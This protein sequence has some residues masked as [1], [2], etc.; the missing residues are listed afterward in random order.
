MYEY[1]NEQFNRQK[2][3]IKKILK[4][5]LA[6][7]YYSKIYQKNNINLDLINTYNDFRSIP[8]LTKSE[9]N[10]NKFDMITNESKKIHKDT[11]LAFGDDFEKK[12]IYLEKN[13]FY[14]KITSGSTGIPVEIFKSKFDLQREY[15]GLNYFRKKINKTFPKGKYIWIW[16]ANKYIRKYFYDNPEMRV[17][18]DG[19]YGYKYMLDEYSIQSFKIL[20]DFIISEKI[21]WITAPP[22][23]LYYYAKYLVESNTCV[24]FKYIECHSEK[25]YDFQLN[26]IQTV[27]GT[28]PISV[29]SSNEIQ[30]MGISCTCNSMHIIPQN[31]FIE[32]LPNPNGSK[33]VVATSLSCMNLPIIRY[34]LCDIGDF[35]DSTKCCCNIKTPIIQLKEYR[36]ND[37]LI[38]QNGK[39]YEPFILTDLV[40]FIKTKFSL[41]IN[42]YVIYQKKYNHLLFCFDEFVLNSIE[43]QDALLKFIK[44]YLFEITEVDFLIDF[45]DIKSMTPITGVNKFKYFIS[46]D[47]Q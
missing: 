11:Y 35:I 39:K 29:Y 7:Q 12:K 14:L 45:A 20:S 1:E 22:S 24:R 15:L 4:V 44:K 3:L 43:D 34:D 18:K 47:F 10:E 21:E 6:S 9:L 46:G 38:T 42:E 13:D 26:L 30:F 8:I 36:N 25:L 2:D 31:V 5:S 19:K 28:K 40:I 41:E 17:Y 23:M 33:K 27:F 16:P 32:L 37:F